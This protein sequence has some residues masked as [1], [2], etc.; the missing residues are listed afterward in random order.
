LLWEQRL[1]A[2]I[3]VGDLED[4]G[5]GRIVVAKVDLA[6]LKVN[7]GDPD[8]LQEARSLLGKAFNT[9]WGGSLEY[10]AGAKA[11]DARTPEG[12]RMS[13]LRQGFAE[14]D[15]PQD[16]A[17]LQYCIGEWCGFDLE[18]GM[19][20]V[21]NDLGHGDESER[22]FEAAMSAFSTATDMH[23]AEWFIDKAAS[24]QVRR[25]EATKDRTAALGYCE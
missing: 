23:L 11:V 12:G 10:L 16:M 22:I 18:L 1:C 5:L 14:G 19:A 4:G 20:A 17:Q 9:G 25:F 3:A 13:P 15:G 7:F 6:W 8:K 21:L 24:Y 2:A